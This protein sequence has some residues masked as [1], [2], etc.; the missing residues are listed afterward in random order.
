M[1]I[2]LKS[3]PFAMFLLIFGNINL[4]AEVHY[5]HTSVCEVLTHWPKNGFRYVAIDADVFSDGRHGTMLTDERCVGRGL[6]LGDP[7][8]NADQSV[9]EFQKVVSSHG[10]PG[11]V[12]RH[13]R[14]TFLGKLKVKRESNMI[15]Y[16]VISV[17][18]LTE[19]NIR[20]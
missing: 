15:L 20:K 6:P 10:S 13:V 1:S 11:T 16:S 19:A 7:L 9:A 12:G 17:K 14:G 2:S 4:T 3:T 8:P 18:G 5:K